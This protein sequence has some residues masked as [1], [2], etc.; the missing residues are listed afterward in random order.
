MAYYGKTTSQVAP[1]APDNAV[2]AENTQDAGMQLYMEAKDQGREEKK[3]REAK[4]NNESPH[5]KELCDPVIELAAVSTTCKEN[6]SH[7]KEIIHHIDLNKTPQ[8]KP[9]RRKHRP[10]VITAGKPKR[11]RKPVTPKPAQS[12]ENPTGKRKYVRK[13]GLNTASTPQTEV[14]GEWNKPLIPES[15]K[16]TCRRSLNF[17]IGEQQDGN[18]TRREN[19]TIHFG[20]EIGVPVKETQA[21]NNEETQGPSTPLLKSNPPGAKPNTNSRENGSKRKGWTIDLDGNENRA[22]ILSSSGTSTGILTAG[23]QVVGFKRKHSGNTEHYTSSINQTGIQYNILQ[24]HYP[25][26]WVQF[27]NVQKKRRS[28]KGKNSSTCNTSSVSATKDVQVAACP[29]EDARSSPYASSSIFWTPGSE[30]NAV[31]VPVV[32]TATE[33]AIHDKPQPFECNLSLGQRRQTK[34]RSTV[35]TR[36]TCVDAER[37][38]TCIDALVAEMRATLTRKKRTKKRSTLVSSAYSCTS[39]MQQHH[40][41][42]LENNSLPL[43][44]SLGISTEPLIFRCHTTNNSIMQF[45]LIP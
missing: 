28:E 14:P 20:R 2:R 4:H 32:I 16:K 34:R 19:T 13:K 33:R 43:D 24:A 44:N 38:P 25:E 41:F 35:P 39:E 42:V 6:H 45:V 11:D 31:R 26:C 7:N 37:Q 29:P 10:K 30:H 15:A 27:P 36:K 22:Q 1:P 18:S 5:N 17:D 21:S 12:K 9:K 23:L 40:K 8:Q 3:V